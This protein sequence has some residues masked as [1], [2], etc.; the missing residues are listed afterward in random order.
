M[1]TCSGERRIR[2]LPAFDP[3]LAAKHGRVLGRL[4][5]RD[6]RILGEALRAADENTT[7]LVVSDHGFAPFRRSFNLNAWLVQN[8]YLVLRAGA[9]PQGR[10]IFRDADWSRTRAYG[11][12]S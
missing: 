11:L 9:S 4:L 3:E 1:G 8:G 5:P 7:V 2:S 12:V 10:D 6:G